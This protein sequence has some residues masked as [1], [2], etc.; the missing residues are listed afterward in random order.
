VKRLVAMLLFAGCVSIVDERNHP[1]PCS[2]GWTCCAAAG[3]CVP[4]NEA[5]PPLKPNPHARYRALPPGTAIDLGDFRCVS[6]PSEPTENCRR[7][8]DDASLEYDPIARRLW[9]IGTGT[10]DTDSLFS[11]DPATARWTQH[12]DATPCAERTPANHDV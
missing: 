7:V 11:F 2:T 6:L 9:L 5:C 12:Y 8:T 10:T 4:M 3:V 1:C